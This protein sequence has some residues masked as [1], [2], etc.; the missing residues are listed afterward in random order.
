MTQ[1]MVRVIDVIALK[2][3]TE[4]LTS[5]MVAQVYSPLSLFHASMLSRPHSYFYPSVKVE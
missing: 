1:I 2:G 3:T 4:T 5:K